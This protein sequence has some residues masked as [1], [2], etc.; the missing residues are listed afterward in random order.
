MIHGNLTVLFENKNAKP[1][2]SIIQRRC[3]DVVAFKTSTSHILKIL[4]HALYYFALQQ[5]CPT[6]LSTNGD[7]RPNGAGHVTAFRARKQAQKK[8]RIKESRRLAYPSG[9]LTSAKQ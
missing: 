1:H 5:D 2:R 8:A 6:Q 3:R 4:L 7:P 9:A